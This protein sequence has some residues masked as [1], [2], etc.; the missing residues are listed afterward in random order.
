[1]GIQLEISRG[2]RAQLFKNLTPLGKHASTQNLHRF[3]TAIREALEPFKLTT[4]TCVCKGL[5]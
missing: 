3:V 4:E 5:D 2:L 1:M